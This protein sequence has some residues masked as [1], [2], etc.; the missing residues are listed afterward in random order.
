M[1]A[2]S[3]TLRRATENLGYVERLLAESDLPTEDVR[4]SP[5]RFYVAFDG[6]DRVGVG[7]IEPV[8][9]AGLLRSVAVEP[10]RRGEG[11]GSALCAALETRAR[12]EG[13]ETLYLLTTT[14][15]D[16]FAGRGYERVERSAVPAGIRETTEFAALCPD[17]AVCLRRALGVTG[18]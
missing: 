16:F 12:A 7:G 17:S 11:Y 15:A 18:N 4:S 2:T 5:A 1:D 3:V 14:A 13:I 6:D 9:D 8:G 10:S